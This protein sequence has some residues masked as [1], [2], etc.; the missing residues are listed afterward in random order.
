MKTILLSA[1][2]LFE[3]VKNAKIVWWNGWFRIKTTQTNESGCWSLNTE[4]KGKGYMWIKFKNDICKVRGFGGGGIGD[5]L[6]TMTDYA[7]YIS[8]PPYNNI[9]V[10]YDM[11]TEQGS[12]DH[13]YWGAASVLNSV[14]EYYTE[15]QND[16]F[17]AINPYVLP[18]DIFIAPNRT[19]GFALMAKKL[20]NVGLGFTISYGLLTTPLFS[21]LGID[22]NTQA[23]L[24]FYAGVTTAAVGNLYPDVMIGVNHTTSDNLKL[25]AYHELAH[26]G[27]FYQVN[28]GYWLD[29]VKVEIEADGWGDGT[30]VNAGKVELVEGWAEHIGKTYT[31][32]Y[33]GLSHSNDGIGIIGSQINRHVIQLERIGFWFIRNGH[34]PIGIYHDL[35]DDNFNPIPSSVENNAVTNDSIMGFENMVFFQLWSQNLSSP[36]QLREEL[37]SNLPPSVTESQI[38][39]LFSDYGF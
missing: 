9:V 15:A 38:D 20:D 30:E 21:E 10:N 28:Q 4:E 19:D 35:I 16:G 23:S 29:I 14:E 25:V 17:F 6:T 32:R 12:R 26:T 11:W 5:L 18:L 22:F 2:S 24:S 27:F 34:I 8:S 36:A 39:N 7:G 37:K 33:Y 13:A 31:D 1:Y 3:G